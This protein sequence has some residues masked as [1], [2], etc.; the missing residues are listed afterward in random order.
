MSRKIKLI[1]NPHANRGRAWDIATLLQSIVERHGGGSWAATEYPTHASDLAEQAAQEG[2]EIVV[3]LGGDGTVHEIVNGL[4]RVPV[5]IR[6]ALAAVPLGSG[7]DFC[8]HQGI[9]EDVELAM[10]RAFTGERKTIDLGQVID[11]AGRTEFID[12]TLG[13]GFDAAVTIYSYRITRLKGFSMYLWAVIQTIMRNHVAPRMQI[14]TDE[15]SFEQDVLMLVLCNGPREGG[16][17]FVAPDARSDDGIFHYAMIQRVSRPMMFR[18]IP[19]VMRG[20][21]GRFKQVRM[22]K[23]HELKLTSEMPITVHIDGEIYAGFT[24]DLYKLEVKVLPE[25]LTVIV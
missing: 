22:G 20:T 17:F 23:F 2:Y 15:E 9:P 14:I 16:G 11:N 3:A 21:H 13:I 8:S 12:N 1:F 24:S 18:L 10:Q 7:N 6:P 19:E 5:N 4:M 25:A